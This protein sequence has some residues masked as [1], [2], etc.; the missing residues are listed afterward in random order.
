MIQKLFTDPNNKLGIYSYSAGKGTVSLGSGKSSGE[1]LITVADVYGNKSDLKFTINEGQP[2]GPV[3][4]EADP[5]G[6]GKVL[7]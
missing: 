1:V 6:G 7:L 4:W 5:A 3:A 2:A